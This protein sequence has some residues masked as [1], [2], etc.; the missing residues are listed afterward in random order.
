MDGIGEL[1][2]NRAMSEA[3]RKRERAVE[4]KFPLMVLGDRIAGALG[5]AD[6]GERIGTALH[7]SVGAVCGAIHGFVAQRIPLE[8]T[9][10]AQPVA[11]GMLAFDEFAFAAFGLAP[12]PE[13][14]PKSTHARAAVA[15]ITYGFSLAVIYEG[16]MS[17]SGRGSNDGK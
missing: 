11:M 15:H 2:Y 13:A 16:L 12:P 3:D 7:W 1:F 9:L 4:P 5:I 8:R 14:F 6:A 10:F 17:F